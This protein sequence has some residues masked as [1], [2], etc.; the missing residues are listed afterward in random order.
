MIVRQTEAL[1]ASYP[2]VTGVTGDALAVAWQRVEHYIAHRFTPRE[3]VWAVVSDGCEWFPPL[4]PVAAIMV[5]TSELAAYEPDAGE[6]G[7]YVLPDGNVTVTA[8][9]GAEPA[10]AA[11]LEAV[12]RLATYQAEASPLPAGVTRLSSGSLDIAVRA[13]MVHPAQA[14]INSGAADLLRAYRRF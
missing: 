5:E 14:I 9:I 13:E 8:T 10:P 6:T 2:A 4:G 11:V 1:P 7:G 12:R 3:V